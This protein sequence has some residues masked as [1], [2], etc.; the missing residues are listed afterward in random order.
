MRDDDSPTDPTTT[1]DRARVEG[2][3][4]AFRAAAAWS[5][6]ALVVG[7]LVYFA[8]R[9]AARIG[10]VVLAL[11]AGLLITAL[12]RPVSEWFVRRGVPRLA[13]A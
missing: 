12:I 4:R 5:W 11:F 10:L 8:F 1:D 6:R 2:I 7:A 9:L 13:G 3:P